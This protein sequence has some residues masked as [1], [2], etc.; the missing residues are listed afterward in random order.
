MRLQGSTPLRLG[1]QPHTMQD[2]EACYHQ[3][4]ML[5]CHPLTHPIPVAHEAVA[6]VRSSYQCRLPVLVT[7][8]I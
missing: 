3:T 5:S 1:H 6:L 2:L 4:I 8:D 7:R